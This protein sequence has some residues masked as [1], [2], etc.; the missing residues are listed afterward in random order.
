MHDDGEGYGE[1]GEQEE[2]RRLPKVVVQQSCQRRP[3]GRGDP[4][5]EHRRADDPAL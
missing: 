1:D 2:C 3:G 5:R 4:G